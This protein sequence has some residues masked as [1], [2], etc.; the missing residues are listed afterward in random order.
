MRSAVVKR[1][2]IKPIPGFEGLYSATL[3]GE[4]WSHRSMMFLK[5][6][7]TRGGYYRVALATNGKCTKKHV[8]QLVMMAFVGHPP[9]GCNVNHKNS[10]KLDNRLCNLEY[11]TQRENIHHAIEA[12]T[13]KIRGED[14]PRGKLLRHQV[15]EILESKEKNYILAERYKV[16]R[17][18]I[19]L[20]RRRINWRFL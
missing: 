15:I 14:A 4:V 7:L 19:S 18:A 11:C 9:D 13:N 17:T 3:T 5:P 8:H 6:S 16:S 20:I 10:K 1:D 2:C 12:G